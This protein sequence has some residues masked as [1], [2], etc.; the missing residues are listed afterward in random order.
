M[1]V[2]IKKNPVT[3]D[4]RQTL[5]LLTYNKSYHAHKPLRESLDTYVYAT[6]KTLQQRE[7]NKERMIFAEKVR[8]QRE[9]QFDAWQGNLNAFQN[10]G[11][12]IEYFKKLMRDKRNVEGNYTTWKATY[13]IFRR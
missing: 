1:S 8:M 10:Q 6:P 7:H 3:K 11:S 4:G 9:A 13:C 5:F 2:H 12:F